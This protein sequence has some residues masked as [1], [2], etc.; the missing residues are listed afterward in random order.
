MSTFNVSTKWDLTDYDLAYDHPKGGNSVARI[1]IVS[2]SSGEDVAS[3]SVMN[4]NLGLKISNGELWTGLAD[5]GT[6]VEKIELDFSGVETLFQLGTNHS[7]GRMGGLGIEDLR[8]AS[9]TLLTH[10]F[11]LE[12]EPIN[13]QFD[14]SSGLFVAEIRD[15][16][17]L[18][19]GELVWYEKAVQNP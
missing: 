4:S 8:D 7:N 16:A 2:K 11:Y 13:V 14:T 18:Q 6:N 17:S 1:R 5:H 15:T 10:Y 19:P 9:R 12:T 3:H